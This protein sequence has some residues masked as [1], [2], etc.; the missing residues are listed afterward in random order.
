[1]NGTVRRIMRDRATSR[2]D[3]STAR[4]TARLTARSAALL[5]LA[6]Q[7][8]QFGIQPADFGG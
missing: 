8:Q 2:L 1:M 6:A 4:S 5:A 7:K 3:E